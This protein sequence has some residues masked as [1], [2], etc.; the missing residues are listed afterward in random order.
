MSAGCISVKR[1]SAN[2]LKGVTQEPDGSIF[3]YLN[4][5]AD[6]FSLGILLADFFNYLQD[7]INNQLTNFYPGG[8]DVCKVI[9]HYT[10]CTN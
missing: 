6:E 3:A 10:P 2:G 5:P 9:G 1:L 7:H 4:A 8:N